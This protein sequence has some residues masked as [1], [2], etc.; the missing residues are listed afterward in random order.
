MERNG[1]LRGVTHREKYACR[2]IS[3]DVW[4]GR[5][6][7]F[8][9]RLQL[10]SSTQFQKRKVQPTILR[11][12]Y[13]N[14]GRAEVWAEQG[15]RKRSSGCSSQIGA[16]RAKGSEEQWS[17]KRMLVL[18][19]PSIRSLILRPCTA[20]TLAAPAHPLDYSVALD[21]GVRPYVANITA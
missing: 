2:G 14:Y 19:T 12:Q 11:K 1:A 7:L 4:W 13:S 5:E 3:H 17:I 20:C 8:N 9:T 6:Q 16:R 18:F 10:N 15:R 21:S